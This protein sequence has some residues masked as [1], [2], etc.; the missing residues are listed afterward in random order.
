MKLYSPLKFIFKQYYRRLG[1]TQ[2]PQEKMF[3]DIIKKGTKTLFG[4]D[5]NFSK[6]K[7]IED[8]Y[9]YVPVSTYKNIFPYID[10]LMRGNQNTLWSSNIK[11]LTKSSGTTNN[12][13][14]YSPVS[15]EGLKENFRKA[16]RDMISIFLHNYPDSDLL[17]GKNLFLSGSKKH[18]D[19]KIAKINAL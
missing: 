10:G 2:K 12:K 17:H 5:H 11:Y 7:T 19:V 9:R 3:N 14:K 8:F 6:I 18:I 1:N 16:E 15:P 13:I 4:F